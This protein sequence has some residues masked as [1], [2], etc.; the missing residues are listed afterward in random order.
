MDESVSFIKKADK[1]IW[2]GM[3]CMTLNDIQ[4]IPRDYLVPSDICEYL[5]CSQYSIN[6]QAQKEPEK[7]GFPVIVMGSR[8]RIPKKAFIHFCT[9]GRKGMTP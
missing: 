3:Y 8:V 7:L 4:A 6:I 5:G 2:K 9:Y 1:T